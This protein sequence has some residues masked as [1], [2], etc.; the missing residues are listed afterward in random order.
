MHGLCNGIPVIA[1]PVHLPSSILSAASF[2]TSPILRTLRP[3]PR[4]YGEPTKKY[5]SLNRFVME[6]QN[7]RQSLTGMLAL[8]ALIINALVLKNGFVHSTHWY[9]CLFIS[10]PVLLIAVIK[11]KAEKV[12]RSF[13]K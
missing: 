4:P 9:W 8:I 2:I 11:L 5:Y 13:R 3:R 6:S 12:K 1:L 7:G 10:L